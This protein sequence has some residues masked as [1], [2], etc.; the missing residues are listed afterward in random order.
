MNI[1]TPS[2]L[3]K[4]PVFTGPRSQKGYGLGGILGGLSRS[5]MPLIK[6]GAK[7]LGRE[8]FNTGIGIAQDALGVKIS[9]QQP[10]RDSAKLDA[11]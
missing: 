3:G 11:I 7:T 1:I 2:K 10:R 6:Q 5:A 4:V 8:V 9:R